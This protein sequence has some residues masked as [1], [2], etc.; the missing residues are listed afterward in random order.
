MDQEGGALLQED[1]VPG[2]RQGR[3][4]VDAGRL[5]GGCRLSEADG[6]IGPKARRGQ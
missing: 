5:Q 3:E 6:D 2:S 1:R 4:W